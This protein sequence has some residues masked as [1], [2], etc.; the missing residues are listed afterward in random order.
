MLRLLFIALPVS[1]LFSG[2]PLA[3]RLVP[4][5]RFYGYRTATTF[6]SLGAWYQLNWATGIALIAAGI[7]GGIA[8]LAL[9][10]GLFGLKPEARYLTGILVTSLALLACLIPVV[11]YSDKF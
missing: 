4:P 11:I 8:V 1:L 7:V 3:L 10:L 2:I 9:A 5:N 6:A